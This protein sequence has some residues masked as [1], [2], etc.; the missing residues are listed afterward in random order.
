MTG[1]SWERGLQ[2]DRARGEVGL[3]RRLRYV[4]QV[5]VPVDLHE[6]GEPPCVP[7]SYR[8]TRAERRHIRVIGRTSPL[9]SSA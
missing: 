8:I 7:T 1:I 2:S 9:E 4:V 6:H 5:A 3:V